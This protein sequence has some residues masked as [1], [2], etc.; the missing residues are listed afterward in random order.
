[1]KKRRCKKSVEEVLIA[2]TNVGRRLHHYIKRH[3]EENT[4]T[5]VAHI[6]QSIPPDVRDHERYTGRVPGE[7]ML[8]R[9]YRDYVATCRD[10]VFTFIEYKALVDI[11]EDLM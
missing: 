8:E 2:G 7:D 3:G 11:M 4:K 1:M 10:P 6:R 9:M 5:A